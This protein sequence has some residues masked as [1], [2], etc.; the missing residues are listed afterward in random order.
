VVSTQNGVTIS[1]IGGPQQQQQPMEVEQQQQQH[2]HQHQP[3]YQYMSP[4]RHEFHD[5]HEVAEQVEPEVPAHRMMTVTRV[6]DHVEFADSVL[7]HQSVPTMVIRSDSPDDISRMR[8]SEQ[9]TDQAINFKM[10][11]R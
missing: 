11:A 4:L 9:D 5:S 7:S 1:Q 8:S 3:R 6:T 2:Q 10:E